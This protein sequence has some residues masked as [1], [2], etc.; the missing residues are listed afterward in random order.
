MGLVDE[1]VPID[2]VIPRAVAW[3]RDLLSCP[4]IAMAATRRLARA[5]LR[6]AFETVTPALLDA[7]VESW[8]ADETQSVM[9][10]LAAKL[11]KPA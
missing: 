10:T 9:R 1:V 8:F 6:A 5:P 7:I 3:T 4:P 11:G 2:E